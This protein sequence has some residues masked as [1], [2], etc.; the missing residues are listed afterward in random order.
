[1]QIAMITKLSVAVQRLPLFAVFFNV[2]HCL[3]VTSFPFLHTEA[4]ELLL[5]RD[6]EEVL[7]KGCRIC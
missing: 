3:Y 4:E 6:F 5:R 2:F 1:M 7:S